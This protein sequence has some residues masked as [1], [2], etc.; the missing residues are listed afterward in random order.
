MRMNLCSVQGQGMLLK[1]LLQKGRHCYEIGVFSLDCCSDG[2]REQLTAYGTSD[3]TL[4]AVET[5]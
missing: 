2:I 5:C 4:K 1:Q 3:R